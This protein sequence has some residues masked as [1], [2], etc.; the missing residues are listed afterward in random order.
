M[1]HLGY[2][3]THTRASTTQW[4]ALYRDSVVIRIRYCSPPP[5]GISPVLPFVVGALVHRFRSYLFS[6][7][8]HLRAVHTCL[9]VVRFFPACSRAD[10]TISAHLCECEPI[11]RS[12]QRRVCRAENSQGCCCCFVATMIHTFLNSSSRQFVHC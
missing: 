2:T 6:S 7:G 10:H 9:C 1:T 3:H 4:D 5:T 8:Y 11:I 12:R